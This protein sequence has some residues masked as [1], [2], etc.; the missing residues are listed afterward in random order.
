MKDVASLQE[1][2]GQGAR[3]KITASLLRIGMAVPSQSS[4]PR[5]VS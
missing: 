5:V 1:K 3:H 2:G 4:I